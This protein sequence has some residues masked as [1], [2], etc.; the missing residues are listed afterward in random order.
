MV[1]NLIPDVLCLEVYDIVQSPRTKCIDFLVVVS[2]SIEERKARHKSLDEEVHRHQ[3]HDSA[4]FDVEEGTSQSDCSGD[5]QY[6]YEKHRVSLTY[7][8]QRSTNVA[9]SSYP[10]YPG[11][12]REKT[13]DTKGDSSKE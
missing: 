6:G 3:H 11:F 1:C 8:E 2:Y 5:A 9:Q 13:G 12:G 7:V 10:E 4:L